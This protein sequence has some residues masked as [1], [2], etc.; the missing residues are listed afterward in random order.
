MVFGSAEWI[1]ENEKAV[2]Q[3]FLKHSSDHAMVLLDSLPNQIRS[4]S[5]FIYDHR[6]SSDSVCREVVQ[7]SW[8][9][10]VIGSRMFQVQRKIK[11]VRSDLLE[12][13]KKNCTNSRKLIEDINLQLN[14]MCDAGGQ[15]D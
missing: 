1:V 13:R 5:R 11:S 4:K 2:V 6:W 14:E 9:V 8:N 10:Q 12:W 3:H 15:R 7:S